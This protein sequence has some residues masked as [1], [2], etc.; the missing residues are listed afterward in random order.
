MNKYIH[1]LDGKPAFFDG[2]QLC[3]ADN[4]RH[5]NELLVDSLRTI[6]KH[7]YLSNEFRRSLGY[8][9]ERTRYSYLRVK[10]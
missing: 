2:E 8:L 9:S 1:L 4:R 6:R 5:L 3:F 7:W 10:V